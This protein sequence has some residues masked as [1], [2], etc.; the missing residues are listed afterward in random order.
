MNQHASLVS[1]KKYMEAEKQININD[2]NN[3]SRI[4]IKIKKMFEDKVIVPVLRRLKRKPPVGA[5]FVF[6]TTQTKAKVN[7]PAQR[8]SIAKMK[9]AQKKSKS[10]KVRGGEKVEGR[11]NGADSKTSRDD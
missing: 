11:K 8:K 5:R 10:Q 1:L 9:N 7:I 6:A 4:N 3:K 2:N